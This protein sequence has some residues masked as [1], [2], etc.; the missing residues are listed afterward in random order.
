MP[1]KTS[2]ARYQGLT[3][4]DCAVAERVFNG[5]A[6]TMR[7][8]FSSTFFAGAQPRLRFGKIRGEQDVWQSKTRGE[9]LRRSC[10]ELAT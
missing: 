8:W 2:I 9:A 1:R 3:G 7:L 5:L 6:K 10:A 4:C